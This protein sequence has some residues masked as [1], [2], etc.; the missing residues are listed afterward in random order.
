[1]R[2]LTPEQEAHIV[3]CKQAVSDAVTALVN[4]WSPE[5]NGML[6]TGYVGFAKAVSA[7]SLE[8]G[9]TRYY[10]F[11]SDG[12]DHSSAIGLNQYHALQLQHESFANWNSGPDTD[13]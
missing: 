10:D 12:L 6:V 8:R 11:Y 5:E 4:A 3:E 13:D 1:M 2:E 9:G 7:G